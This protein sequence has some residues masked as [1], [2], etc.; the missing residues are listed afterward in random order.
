MNTH[1]TKRRN[2]GMTDDRDDLVILVD[3]DGKEEEF[4]YLDTIELNDNEYVVLVPYREEESEKDQDEDE[5]VILKI[6]HGENGEDSFVTI[7]DEDEL[8]EVFEEF[9]IRMEEEFDPED[10]E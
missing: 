7:D 4:E 9:K 10:E 6:D 2:C 1:K 5:V 8:D 3:E